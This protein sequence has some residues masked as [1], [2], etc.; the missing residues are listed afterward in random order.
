MSA[1]G[2]RGKTNCLC[3]GK[4]DTTCAAV[5]GRKRERTGAEATAVAGRGREGRGGEERADGT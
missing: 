4:G 3:S 2:Q 1:G 5:L